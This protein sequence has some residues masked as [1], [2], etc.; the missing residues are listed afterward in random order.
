MVNVSS[1]LAFVPLA[2][3]P[4]YCATKAAMHSYSQ[5]LRFQLRDTSVQVIELAPP[6]VATDL[7]P[8]HA[9]NPRSM[10]LDAYIQESLAILKADPKTHEICVENVKPLR[11][12]EASGQYDKVFGMLNPTQ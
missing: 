1:G 5:S 11:N 12:A 8:G 4:T 6:A 2:T 10:P 7:M 3:T 9:Q